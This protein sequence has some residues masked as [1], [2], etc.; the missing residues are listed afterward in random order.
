MAELYLEDKIPNFYL[1]STSG[2]NYLFQNFREKYE[3]Y[4]HLVV[5]FSWLLVSYLPR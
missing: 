3:G 1:P 4:W 2:K 5:F